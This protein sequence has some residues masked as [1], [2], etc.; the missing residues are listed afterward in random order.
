M[1]TEKTDV[2]VVGAAA[3]PGPGALALAVVPAAAVVRRSRRALAE[4][5]AAAPIG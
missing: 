4:D 1:R 5:E 2:L 3:G